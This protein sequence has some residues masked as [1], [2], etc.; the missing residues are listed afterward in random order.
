V[1]DD[2]A[3]G[4][5][6]DIGDGVVTAAVCRAGAAEVLHLECAGSLPADT[7]HV[8]ARVGAPEPFYVG[9]RAVAAAEVAAGIV[10]EV[11]ALAGFRAGRAPGWTVLTVPPSWGGYRGAALLE[12]LGP[13]AGR[14]SLVSAAVAA[15]RQHVDTGDLPADPAVVVYDAGASTVDTAVVGTTPAATL[16]HLGLP[17][18]PL[19]WGGCDIDD[20][21]LGHVAGSLEHPLDPADA[22]GRRALRAA[23]VAAKEA[24][25]ADT[26]ASLDAGGDV[27]LRVLREELDELIAPAV[28][29]TV[30]HLLAT[31]EAAGLTADDLD[32]VVLAGGSARVPLVAE[33]LSADLGRPLV[34]GPSPE[35]T[36]A[37]GAARLAAA[38]AAAVP[39]AVPAAIAVPST[40]TPRTSRGAAGPPSIPGSRRPGGR[41]AAGS[42]RGARVLVVAAMF[43][44]LVLLVPTLTALFP[45]G[46]GPASTGSGDQARAAD[47]AG[48]D[49]AAGAA[50][51]GGAS[52]APAADV[53]GEQAGTG[54]GSAQQAVNRPGG[55]TTRDS[56]GVA[57]GRA[58]ATT[59][60][61]AGT[62]TAAPAVP[63]GTTSGG[64]TAPGTPG[65]ASGSPD[66]APEPQPEPEPQPTPDPTQ[67]PGPE[68]DP[69]PAEPTEPTP[70]PTDPAGDP[71]AE[72]QQPPPT[73]A[74]P[75]PD[76]VT[77]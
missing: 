73:E 53:A 67:E 1:D 28:A 48:T 65:A 31:I 8:M 38:A 44:G 5:G 75:S 70:E 23:V 42:R 64:T 49:T 69:E 26:V 14:L 9:G 74:G 55:G 71:G 35:C 33:R 20:A 24:L 77:P 15:T 51:P 7:P 10:R 39:A 45:V 63:P 57:G 46:V 18:R 41:S 50:P 43:A 6:I 56:T 17:P 12:A 21:L 29:D 58:R 3:Y 72:E 19:D 11:M 25:S 68:P 22:A 16:E 32:A 30:T 27:P 60:G 66:P 52:G 2:D 37:L 54:S 61:D 62:G 47:T 13:T 36:V 4:L 34:V 59:G 76:G 40:S